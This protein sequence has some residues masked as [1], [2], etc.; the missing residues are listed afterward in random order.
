V[1][2]KFLD[3]MPDKKLPQDSIYSA[4]KEIIEGVMSG[5]KMEDIAVDV[6][7]YAEQFVDNALKPKPKVRYWSGGNVG[8]IWAVYTFLW[9]TIWVL[10]IY[11]ILLGYINNIFQDTLLGRAMKMKELKQALTQ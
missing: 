4:G 2:T 3:N 7:I 9:P 5:R 6:D 8:M 10:P 1:K 11:L